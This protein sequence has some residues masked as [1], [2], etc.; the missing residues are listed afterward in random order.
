MEHIGGH[1]EGR[2]EDPQL[3]RLLQLQPRRLVRCRES[4]WR[5][6]PPVPVAP[7]RVLLQTKRLRFSF[8]SSFFSDLLPQLAFVLS[9][10]LQHHAGS[11]GEGSAL[12]GRNGTLFQ[13]HGG[14]EKDGVNLKCGL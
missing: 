7:V 10:M 14:G 6:L 5:I 12:S 9:D 2:G 13:L 4:M 1:S 3:L 11:R 8:S